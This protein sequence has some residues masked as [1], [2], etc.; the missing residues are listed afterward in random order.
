[1]ARIDAQP[2]HSASTSAARR[3]ADE[4][5]QAL[6]ETQPS[7]HG[8][9][10]AVQLQDAWAQASGAWPRLDV[11]PEAFA[12]FVAAR[13]PAQVNIAQPLA[14][15]RLGEL[16]LA[17][18]CSLR[19]VTAIRLLQ[20][21]YFPAIERSL[22]RRR[23]SPAFIDETCA[24]LLARLIVG[25]GGRPLILAYRGTGDLVAWLLISAHRAAIREQ[26]RD[27]RATL[28]GD[29]DPGQLAHRDRGHEA[30]YEAAVSSKLFRASF[31]EALAR[32][33]VQQRTVLR[34]HY[35]EGLT[36]QEVASDHGAHRATAAR[37]LAG[38]R[39]ELWS[40]TRSILQDRLGDQTG[41]ESDGLIRDVIAAGDGGHAVPEASAW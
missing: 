17:F 37:W 16:L 8:A 11:L 2:C 10:L 33:T 18:A 9:T 22:K 26:Q 3:F 4:M 35:I 13:V 12:G 14:A 20:A 31:A 32:L 25:E 34:Q 19:D 24:L 40:A 41:A 1:L 15:L 21:N 23:L 5:L 29:G 7:I 6:A 36:L 30:G 38:A 39:R 28:H 27:G